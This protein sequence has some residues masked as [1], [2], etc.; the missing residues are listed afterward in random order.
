MAAM[1]VTPANKDSNRRPAPASTL[2]EFYCNEGPKIF[3]EEAK[4][5]K[6]LVSKRGK[7]SDGW[8]MKAFNAAVN[9]GSYF[10][11]KALF[12]VYDGVYLRKKSEEIIGDTLLANTRSTLV[13]PAY[14]V[15]NLRPVVFSTHQVMSSY[16]SR[17]LDLFIIIF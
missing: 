14:D 10:F 7:P 16:D 2:E 9:V 6:Q 5:I 11:A 8:F 1:L 15:Q 4:Q 12:S 13:I 17:P 3:S